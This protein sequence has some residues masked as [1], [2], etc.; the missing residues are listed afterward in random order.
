MEFNLSNFEFF[1]NNVEG[2]LLNILST[3][4]SNLE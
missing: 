4:T 3:D 1:C 2:G